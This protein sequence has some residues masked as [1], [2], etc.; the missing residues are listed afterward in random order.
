[1]GEEGVTALGAG[2]AAGLEAGFGVLGGW[3]FGAGTKGAGAW[4]LGAEAGDCARWRAM[5][6]AW[7]M[8]RKHVR[9]VRRLA[10]A[11]AYG[12][13]GSAGGS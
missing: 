3:G 1:M 8:A 7:L 2:A 11:I 5:A 10:A 13:R 6:A 9:R 4:K 12:I